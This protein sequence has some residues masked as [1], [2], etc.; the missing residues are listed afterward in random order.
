MLLHFSSFAVLSAK[1]YAAEGRW[2]EAHRG[3]RVMRDENKTEAELYG[4]HGHTACT[5]GV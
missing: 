1:A 2:L 3:G 4:E 5:K